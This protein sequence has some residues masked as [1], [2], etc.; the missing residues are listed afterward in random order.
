M[1]LIAIGDIHGELDHLVRLLERVKPTAEDKV[2]FLGDYVDR[3][4]KIPE[5]VSFLINFKKE[6]PNTVFIRGN[7]EVMMMDGE[8]D[9]GVFLNL[10]LHNGGDSTMKQYAQ[11]EG[12]FESHRFF[13]MDT[14]TKHREF[15]EGTHYFFSHAGWDSYRSLESQWVKTDPHYI[16]WEREHLSGLGRK[17]AEDNWEGVA[18]FGHTPLKFPLNLPQMV[19]IDTGACFG[20]YL[21]A[22]VLGKERIF[23]T[24][25]VED[26]EN[27]PV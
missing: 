23:Y 5:T 1:R 2:I 24:S 26:G 8:K 16:I 12:L 19:G 18:V 14:K 27:L 21:T 17:L 4:S 7:H 11:T 9:D 6:F 25:E 3:G 10:W 13:F 20:N 22:V 15:H